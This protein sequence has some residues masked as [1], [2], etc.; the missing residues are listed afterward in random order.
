MEIPPDVFFLGQLAN[1]WQILAVKAACEL[2][3][4]DYFN[5]GPKSADEVASAAGLNACFVSR[6]LRALSDCGVFQQ[7]APRVF[8]HTE[9]SQLL[10]SDLPQSFKWMVLSD[11]GAERVPAWMSLAE[12]IRS[13]AI[14][15]DHAYGDKDLQFERIIPTRSMSSLILARA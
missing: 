9:R 8:A 10:R 2:S 7:T 5:D 12:S 3:L 13:G 15:F 6:L 11:F 4:A 1:Y 14:A